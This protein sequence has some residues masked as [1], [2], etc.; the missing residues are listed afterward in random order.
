MTEMAHRDAEGHAT[1]GTDLPRVASFAALKDTRLERGFSHGEVSQRLKLRPRQLDRLESG[2]WRALGGAA[3]VR[4]HL[5]AYGKL[6][7]V[8]VEPLIQ[9][10][11]PELSQETLVPTPG[12]QAPLPTES[13]R[14]GFDGGLGGPRKRWGLGLL[15][16]ATVAT[17][18]LFFGPHS[19]PSQ[20]SSWIGSPAE[21]SSRPGH[22]DAVSAPVPV[23]ASEQTTAD[24]ASVS[25]PAIE[26][27]I[28]AASAG[29]TSGMSQGQNTPLGPDSARPGAV[30]EA[31]PRSFSA[32]RISASEESWVEVR[33]PGGAVVYSGIVKPGASVDLKDAPPFALTVG[34][35]H[36]VR[37]EFEGRPVDL[38]PSIT[39][40][41]NVARIKLP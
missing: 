30:A 12:L 11:S 26:V 23:P 27:P 24:T 34:N 2:E 10:L 6:L 13:G 14:F 35:A 19:D 31:P 3:F 5:R 29:V 39:L 9:S 1:L 33:R 41:S 17:L 38:K 40:S 28:S 36:A 16:G 15:I 8:D 25:V 37:L 20:I 18:V 32:L 4:G 21:E 22:A 7:Q